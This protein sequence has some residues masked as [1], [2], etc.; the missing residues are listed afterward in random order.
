M[1]RVC[2]NST[3]FTAL[4]CRV[5]EFYGGSLSGSQRVLQGFYPYGV[6]AQN[7]AGFS[8]RCFQP[9]SCDIRVSVQGFLLKLAF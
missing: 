5:L 1:F 2:Q 6:P 7:P 9:L 4:N 3:K 8:L